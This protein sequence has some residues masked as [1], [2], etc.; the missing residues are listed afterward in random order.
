M[1][2]DHDAILTGQTILTDIKMDGLLFVSKINHRNR[3]FIPSTKNYFAGVQVKKVLVNSGCSSILL[4]I[5]ENSLHS[6]FQQFP[7]DQ[8]IATIGGSIGVGGGSLVLLFYSKNRRGFEVK[9]CQDIVGHSKA[10]TVK[11]LRFSLC[12]EDSQRIL[13]TTDLRDRFGSAEIKKLRSSLDRT[14]AR[15]SHALLG[16]SVLKELSCIKSSTVEF[17]VRAELYTPITWTEVE[18]DTRRLLAQL[19]LPDAF[20]EWEDDDNLCHD[21]MEDFDWEEDY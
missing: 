4:P 18:A 10:L 9:L 1:E 5:A 20:E 3:C 2:A 11:N 13:D 16:Q 8:F 7:S 17:Y 15:R 19:I 14:I 6:L 12:S 21:E